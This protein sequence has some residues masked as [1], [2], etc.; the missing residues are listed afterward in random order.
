MKSYEVIS[1]GAVDGKPVLILIT[2]IREIADLVC[3]CINSTSQTTKAEV[4]EYEMEDTN[5]L[6]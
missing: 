5:P 4:K 6:N 2:P 3:N 1:A